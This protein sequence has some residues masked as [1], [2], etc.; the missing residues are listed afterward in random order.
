M[1]DVKECKNGTRGHVSLLKYLEITQREANIVNY[2][3][4]IS[5]F[6]LYMWITFLKSDK[7]CYFKNINKKYRISIA[8][9]VQVKSLAEKVCLKLI[10]KRKSLGRNKL[11]LVLTKWA[12]MEKVAL[13][14][15][16]FEPLFCWDNCI[17]IFEILCKL[18]RDNI[19]VLFLFA[20]S[21]SANMSNKWK[22]N[23]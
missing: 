7:S 10:V 3:E 6:S 20:Y 14:A 9:V 23:F 19:S 8:L 21:M 1:L 15:K 13:T 18:F 17:V 2:W 5:Q 4:L 12:D 11:V 22:L 16:I